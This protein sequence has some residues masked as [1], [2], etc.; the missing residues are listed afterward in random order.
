[1][2]RLSY[3][4]K[5]AF[6]STVESAGVAAITILTIAAALVICGILIGALQN[7]EKWFLGWGK[8]ASIVL[9][10]KDDFP[11]QDWPTLEKQILK[12]QGIGAVTFVDSK[13]ALERF[14]SRGP[15]AAQ[16]VEGIPDNVLSPAVEVLLAP[17]FADLLVIEKMAQ[18]LQTLTHVESV[19]YGHQEFM[20]LQRIFETLRWV[21]A[22]LGFI[23]AIAIAFIVANT[24][25][26]T[27][28]ARREEISIQLLVGA[29]SNFI[30]T[31]F[32]LEGF[33][34]GCLGS[35][36]GIGALWLFD[37]TLRPI[38]D[39]VLQK[40]LG[41]YSLSF[42]SP[43]LAAELFVAGTVIGILGSA[44]AVRRFLDMDS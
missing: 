25:R 35:V 21:G 13:R 28:Y 17:G 26:L 12:I 34:W 41:T 38:L 15:E 18:T 22:T 6:R 31:P 4:V 1:M 9:Y 27:I 5:Q 7:I 19:D 11:S 42:F 29:T 23:I 20:Q 37:H 39:S 24:I 44:L 2:E 40:T 3:F 10:L 14:R 32:V 30:R 16:L 8:N 33:F 36:V 43:T